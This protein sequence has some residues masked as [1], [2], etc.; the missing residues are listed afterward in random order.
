LSSRALPPAATR[1]RIGGQNRQQAAD[2]RETGLRQRALASGAW[3]L[4]SG[5]RK[6]L[7]PD[8]RPQAPDPL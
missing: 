5:R 3:G 2:T 7:W 1:H 6:R 4:G 8:P